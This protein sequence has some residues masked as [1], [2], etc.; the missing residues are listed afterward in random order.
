MWV[1][2]LSCEW[3]NWMILIFIRMDFNHPSEERVSSNLETYY[4]KLAEVR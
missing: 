4:L 2:L 3:R 1:K